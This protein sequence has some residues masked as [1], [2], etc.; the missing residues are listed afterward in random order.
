MEEIFLL[1]TCINKNQY[2]SFK[3]GAWDKH[4]PK[5]SCSLMLL[6][7]KVYGALFQYSDNVF[8]GFGCDSTGLW[9]NG[10]LIIILLPLKLTFFSLIC[11]SWREGGILIHMIGR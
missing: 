9:L 3:Y 1:S 4:N 8:G 2:Q 11:L 6:W 7:E 10:Q 5:E